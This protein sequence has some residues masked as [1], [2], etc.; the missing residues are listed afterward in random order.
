MRKISTEEMKASTDYSIDG[1]PPFRHELKIRV[2]ID[3]SL[4]RFHRAWAA[5][6]SPNAVMSI[7]A[8]L[9]NGLKLSCFDVPESKLGLDKI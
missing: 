9:I 4:F 3:N 2:I 1:I 5:A 7:D 6:G 8:G